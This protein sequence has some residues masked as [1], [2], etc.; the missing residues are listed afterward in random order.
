[1]VHDIIKLWRSSECLP[2]YTGS[3]TKHLTTKI[4]AAKAHS[5]SERCAQHVVILAVSWSVH[6]ETHQFSQLA[7]NTESRKPQ[8]R[9]HFPADLS[10]SLSLKRPSPGLTDRG[11]NSTFS[12]H[13]LRNVWIISSWDI[14]EVSTQAISCLWN[15]E[16][17]QKLIL[18]SK[19]K[20]LRDGKC[21]KE[22]WEVERRQQGC[23]KT[24]S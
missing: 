23:R 15:Y 7:V 16:V 20:I 14:T 19:L 3:S 5:T 18:L 10:L 2:S 11:F 22:S 13:S 24:T 6:I 8:I 9:K 17:V 12:R 21:V 1:M 4:L